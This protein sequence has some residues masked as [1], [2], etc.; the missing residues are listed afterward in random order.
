[1]RLYLLQQPVVFRPVRLQEEAEVQQRLP[2]D[3][4]YTEILRDQKSA[5]ATVAVEEGVDRLEL[6]VQQA[7]LDE[8]RQSRGVV[9]QE[10]LERTETLGEL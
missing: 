3:A 9:V 4:L 2:K 10:T 6:H 8:C 1:M 5:D 7:G